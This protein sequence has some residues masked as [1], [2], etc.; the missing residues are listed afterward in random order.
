[1]ED[2]QAHGIDAFVIHPR[3]GLP[4]S[5]GWMS[6]RLL[7]CMR[8][9]LTEA[10]RRN[11]WVMLYDEAMYPSGSAGGQVV[12]RNPAFRC[13]GLV[14]EP[15][16]DGQTLV[17]GTARDRRLVAI[18]ARKR[19]GQRYA[20]LDQHVDGVTRGL[21][22]LDEPDADKPAEQSHPAADLLNADASACFIDLVYERFYQE[23]RAFFGTT[24]RAIFTDEPHPLGRLLETGPIPGTTG[25][26]EYANKLL[27][28]DFAPHLPALWFDDEPDAERHRNAWAEAIARRLDDSYYRPLSLWCERHGVAL[29]GHPANPE[30]IGHLRYFHIPGQDIVWRAI[31]PGNASALEGAASTQA[32]AA[33]SAMVHCGRTRNANEFGG[34]FGH[35]L[36]FDEFRWLAGWLLVRGCNLL[37][38][39]AFYYSVRGPRLEERPRDVGPNSPW[40]PQ[41]REF[42]DATRRLCWLNATSDP[43]CPIAILGR[44]RA[45]PWRAAKVCF[46]NQFEF[47]YLEARHL[48]QDARVDAS[49]VTVAGLHYRALVVDHVEAPAEAGPS[50]D[51]LRAAGRLI[52]WRDGR[53]ETL[54]RRLRALVQPALV[55]D[56]PMRDLRVRSMARGGLP[57][58]LL[59]NE[60]EKTLRFTLPLAANSGALILDAASGTADESLAAPELELPPR[61]LPVV[62]ALPPDETTTVDESP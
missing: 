33:T 27:G 39:H 36:T 57:V 52:D 50:L 23:F 8:F 30:D 5:I 13:R 37:I 12:A 21:H 38:P 42:A 55:V 53:E 54:L 59:F 35:G 46:E 26:L 16:Y 40:W 43:V 3:L 47:H 19:T 41:Y 60:G 9:V 2:F 4:E 6:P 49:G 14:C 58:F 45:L 7:G 17:F 20:I 15:I 28:Y 1:M 44:A 29:T 25:I 24:I 10:R 18:V 31:E 34:A 56:P 11:M 32:K 61:R 48:W 51:V 22:Y 62:L